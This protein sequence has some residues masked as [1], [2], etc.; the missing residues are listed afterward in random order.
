MTRSL[1]L[2]FAAIGVQVAPFHFT[3]C[4]SWHHTHGLLPSITPTV[5]LVVSVF[6]RDTLSLSLANLSIS[7]DPL[8][9]PD[10]VA[11]TCSAFT[12]GWT[13]NN[14]IFLYLAVHA[15]LRL[16][17]TRSICLHKW[18][19][20]SLWQTV[21]GGGGGGPPAVAVSTPGPWRWALLSWFGLPASGDGGSSSELMSKPRPPTPSN[22]PAR[23]TPTRNTPMAIKRNKHSCWHPWIKPRPH[24][25]TQQRIPAMPPNTPNKEHTQD[26]PEE[27]SQT[28]QPWPT[29]ER[30]YTRKPH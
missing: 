7:V 6:Q 26:Y 11:S 24:P 29:W 2:A 20:T 17:Q 15:D 16:Q 28:P 21:M 30:A 13:L 27:Q 22:T 12:L 8:T 19:Y 10:R 4:C 14:S 18:M 9:L 5:S 25:Q 1:S 3:A 23:N